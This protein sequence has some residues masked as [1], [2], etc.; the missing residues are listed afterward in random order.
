MNILSSLSADTLHHSYFIEDTDEAFTQLP[1][2]LREMHSDAEMYVRELDSL[3]IDDSRDLI[4]LASM[5]SVGTQIFVYKVQSPTRE[6]QNALLKLLEEPPER[7]HF[8]F[9]VA[10]LGDILPTLLSRSHVL[11]TE[12][13]ESNGAGDA[14]LSAKPGA[15]IELLADIV[16]EKDIAAADSLLKDIEAVVYKKGERGES[17]KHLFSVRTVLHDKGASLKTLLESVALTLPRLK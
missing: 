9:C 12:S 11:G 1:P 7:T 2:A 13:S 4:Q 15:R 8:L 14:F 3:G 16:Q 5:R 6:A 17:V 10:A